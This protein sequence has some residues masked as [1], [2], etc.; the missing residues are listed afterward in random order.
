MLQ[1]LA[2]SMRFQLQR[3]LLRLLGLGRWLGHQVF[4]QPS[5]H[6]DLKELLVCVGGA[7]ALVCDDLA[8]L[9]RTDG[10]CKRDV[11]D[12]PLPIKVG[13]SPLTELGSHVLCVEGK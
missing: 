7:V 1:L 5:L 6:V 9:D 11:L 10:S 2:L 12:L 3:F 8:L 4:V 13:G